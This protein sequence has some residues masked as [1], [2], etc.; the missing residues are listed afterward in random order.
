MT[1]H[2]LNIHRSWSAYD[3]GFFRIE[4]RVF[5]RE[6]L[7]NSSSAVVSSFEKNSMGGSATWSLVTIFYTRSQ[8]SRIFHRPGNALIVLPCL[9]CPVLVLA[10]DCV[11]FFHSSFSFSCRILS[12]ALEMLQLSW[13]TSGFRDTFYVGIPMRSNRLCHSSKIQSSHR[14]SLEDQEHKY[15]YFRLASH[16]C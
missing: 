2:W 8:I 14:C 13:P 1:N 3:G 12:K 5:E 16:F 7:R 6:G 10:T 4:R 9:G 11:G 15:Q